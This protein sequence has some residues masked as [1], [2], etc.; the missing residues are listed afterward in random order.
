MVWLAVGS[1]LDWCGEMTV[2]RSEEQR[3]HFDRMASYWPRTIQEYWRH[4]EE[5]QLNLPGKLM[6]EGIRLETRSDAP[7]SSFAKRKCYRSLC[8]NEGSVIRVRG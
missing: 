1:P 2:I 7:R 3:T 5:R 8:R 4:E 6:A